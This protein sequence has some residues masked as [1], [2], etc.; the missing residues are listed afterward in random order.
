MTLTWYHRLKGNLLTL[1]SSCIL[2]LLMRPVDG[3]WALVG[4]TEGENLAVGRPGRLGNGAAAGELLQR[5][6]HGPGARLV[7]QAP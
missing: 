5:A 3:K 2:S 1:P 4:K 7:S 6:R